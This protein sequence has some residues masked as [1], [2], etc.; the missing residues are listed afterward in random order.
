MM[1]RRRY[2]ERVADASRRAPVTSLLGPRQ[3]G[4]T[5]LARQFAANR[6]ATFFDL[7]LAADRR[8]LA[9]PEMVLGELRGLVVLDEIQAMPELFN[10]LRVLVDRPDSESRFLILG[11]A[12]PDIVRGVSQTLA[13]RVEFVDM[14]GFDLAEVESADL[15]RLWR[16]GGFPNS[17]LAASEADSAAWRTAFVRTFLERD[18]PQIGVAV[19]AAAMRRFWTTLAHYNGQTW[20]A[21][22]LGVTIGVSD[23]TA[24][25]YLDLLAGAFMVRQLQPW[26]E[27]TA[28]R[29]VKAPKVYVRDTGLL[30]ALLG[31]EE[32]R[33]LL[34][35]RRVGASWEAFAVEQVLAAL[36]ARRAWFWGQPR[37]RR[38][39]PH[40]AATGASHRLRDEVQRG[41][42][43]HRDHAPYCRR[44]RSG[45]SLR[46]LP[47]RPRL[48]G[49]SAHH[50]PA[51]SGPAEPPREDQGSVA[52]LLA[53]GHAGEPGTL[54]P[55]GGRK[56]QGGLRQAPRP[57]RGWRRSTWRSG[58]RTVRWSAKQ[59]AARP[60]RSDRRF[61]HGQGCWRTSGCRDN[62]SRR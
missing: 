57:R 61:R 35:H 41:A 7:E 49:G 38:A 33:D 12:S 54:P 44:T 9:N 32:D 47:D 21:S 14:C 60:G 36:R 17:Y 59:E 1:L 28:R 31:I 23:K 19:P 45:P 18:F 4:K 25:R 53:V 48:P 52:G 50:R 24:R 11:S 55:T 27:N 8:R 42:E 2:L 22:R 3:C 15:R 37:R 34:G 5:T 16:R 30:H 43:S 39:R 10:V 58:A 20:N 29:Q 46:R 26:F 40:G 13:G 62:R 6:E 56:G 51:G